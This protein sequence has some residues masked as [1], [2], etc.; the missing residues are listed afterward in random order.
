MLATP[1]FN[2]AYIAVKSI[3]ATKSRI[4][5]KLEIDTEG[6][7][8]P[9]RKL[10]SITRN[11]ED[12]YQ[13][14]GGREQYS[15][16]VVTAID[17]GHGIIEFG[18]GISLSSGETQGGYGDEIMRL[19]IEQ[20]IHEHFE[21][22][23]LIER[24]P[25]G[26]RLKVLSL[27]FI[28]RVA[29]Y[30]SADGK[31]RQWF[32]E[33]YEKLAVMKRYAALQPL[34]VDKVHGG[35][36]AQDK[37]GPKDSSERQS[38]KADE[39]AY[40]LIMQA[41]EQLLARDEPLRFIFSHSALREGWDNPNV[42][43][44]CT[45]NE[46][47]SITRKRQEIGRGLRLP[48]RENGE[49]SFD[50][51]INRLT[52][53]ANESYHD[54][55]K[56]LQEQMRNEWGIEFRDRIVDKRE[57]RT[58]SLKA[59]WLL[60]EDFKALW[61]RIKHHTRYRVKYDSETLIAKTVEHLQQLPM[62]S[63]PDFQVMKGELR[64]TGEGV[65]AELRATYRRA[66]SRPHYTIPD[67]IHYLQR[68]TE[69]TR[70]TLAQILLRSGKLADASLNPQQLLDQ[71]L[72]ATKKALTELLVAGIKYERIAGAEYDMMLFE[73][74][75]LESYLS[76]MLPVEKSI[77]DYV[78][79]NSQIERSFA[80]ALGGR[81]DIKLFIKLPTWFKIET[82]L[83][84]Y[85]PDWAIVKAASPGSD[86]ER[87]YLV[88]ETKGTTQ[89]FDLAES[90]R[91]KIQCGIAHFDALGGVSFSWVKSASEV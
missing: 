11:G 76:T 32:V 1:G 18:N 60:D 67:M 13:L 14:S 6:R 69:L 7:G 49:R 79:Y 39:Q 2:E 41:K 55:A 66:G 47:Q 85:N 65:I 73:S 36:F 63:A 86:E 28:D 24:L 87:L 27:F 43:Q 70:T 82:P 59:G 17:A 33:G 35:Y 45:L 40:H 16:Y 23:L 50:E 74:R 44:I 61:E 52:V 81:Q 19:Q 68:E 31:I 3:T 5:A 51:R 84:T 83:G 57:R 91:Q 21:K 4:T 80:E 9:T 77:Y 64:T 30:A 12:L 78:V 71:T 38:T 88:R 56:A 58:V 90:E 29:N 34:P 42:F 54:F 53:I 62:I 75:E 48:V 22:E 46:T 20:T 10:I 72:T 26:Q 15:G 8:G 25:A 89:L 37:S